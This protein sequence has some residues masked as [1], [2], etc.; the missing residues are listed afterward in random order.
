MAK[1]K[2]KLGTGL[3]T[4]AE[5]A[6]YARVSTRLISR[7][8]YGTKSAEPVISPEYG[9][10]DKVVSFLDFVQTLAIREIRNTE[11]IPLQKIRQAVKLA[12]SKYGMEYPFA[13]RNVTFWD[14]NEIVICPT[15]DE[16]GPIIQASGRQQGQQYF[17]FMWGYMDKLE[18]RNGN[19]CDLYDIFA[20]KKTTI[21][22]DPK[23]RFGEPII[24]SGYS[25]SYIWDAIHVEKGVENVSKIYQ[26][27]LQEVEAVNRF[28]VD[29]L[30]IGATAV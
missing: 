9:D 27:P 30:P 16:Y 29:Y 10:D 6:M 25:A 18:F 4:I 23:I 12:K 7:W 28:Y 19:L 21:K 8:I 3:F 17:R 5:A 11:N 24:P 20:H 1:L 13:M 2:N 26:I 15:G 14:G 22:M